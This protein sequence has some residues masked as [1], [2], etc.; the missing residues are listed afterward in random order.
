MSIP[1]VQSP[2]KT[3]T[4]LVAR[5]L[6]QR[7]NAIDLSE[8]AS[9]KTGGGTF[10]DGTG[11]HGPCFQAAL[12]AAFGTPGSPNGMTNR[13]LNRPLR[14]PAGNF[15][16]TDQL[17]V[18]K[19]VGG[20]IYGQGAWQTRI[21][22][23]GTPGAGI[24]GMFNFNGC[25]NLFMEKMNLE[26]HGSPGDET[27]AINFDWDGDNSGNG[28]DGLHHNHL[29]MM[30][31]SNN[32]GKVII[33]GASNHQ[34]HNNLFISVNVNGAGANGTTGYSVRGAAALN[35][36]II[37]GGGI[38]CDV[39]MHCPPSGGSFHAQSWS[40]GNT[41]TI[42]QGLDFLME[43][44]L[45][46]TI[47][48][49]RSESPRLAKVTNGILNIRDIATTGANPV[50]EINGGRANIET[51]HFVGEVIGTGGSL[52]VM[53]VFFNGVTTPLSGYTGTVIT[54]LG[55]NT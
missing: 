15:R 40:T 47:E 33:I 46:S 6:N 51:C 22:Y 42:L 31:V 53:N 20:Y 7:F 41:V 23:E 4:G 18:N 25:S 30:N 54:T 13:R 3:T 29:Q 24:T 38:G 50:V 44:N 2:F 28:C 34:G 1:F 17:Y 49:G 21:S 26:M 8:F 55:S 43:S 36:C 32:G 10:G 52:S 39:W 5:T 16:I 35:Q 9:L 14:I 12:N 48:Q 19:L 45:V 11:N 27:C 37:G